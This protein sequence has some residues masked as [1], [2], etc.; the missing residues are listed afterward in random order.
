MKWQGWEIQRV[1]GRYTQ[2]L[3][4]LPKSTLIRYSLSQFSECGSIKVLWLCL[5]PRGIDF[6]FTMVLQTVPLAT[7]VIIPFFWQDKLSLV[8]L[9]S[10]VGLS[11]DLGQINSVGGSLGPIKVSCRSDSQLDISHFHM[12]EK[13]ILLCLWLPHNGGCHS[14]IIWSSEDMD[15]EGVKT[16]FLQSLLPR[17]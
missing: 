12:E 16:W 2:H 8:L 14:Q 11:M 1:A 4:K 10:A 13:E 7:E 6:Y 9:H 17:E 3:W 5:G 15:R